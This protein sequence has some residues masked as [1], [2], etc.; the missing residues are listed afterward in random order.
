VEGKYISPLYD[1]TTGV[2]TGYT[3]EAGN[4]LVSTAEKDG[5]SLIMVGLKGAS[6]DMYVDAHNLFNYGFK[7]FNSSVIIAKNTFIQ[8]VGVKNGDSKEISAITESDFS[9]LISKDDIKK[10]QSQVILNDIELPLEK[11]EVIGK[12]E[13]S[14]DGKAIGSVN[15]ITP[16]KVKSTE[17]VSSGK[18]ITIVKTMT[19]VL[20]ILILLVFGLKV[21]NNVRI[22]LN[23][24]RRRKR[25]RSD[26]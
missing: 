20:M 12:I 16:T 13:Y 17:K 8:N 14:L 6:L 11:N 19:V 26:I 5:T 25:I 3:P 2:K 4:S 24:K 23:R 7:N 10:V 15:L 18:L 9:T 22:K 21:Y 1:G